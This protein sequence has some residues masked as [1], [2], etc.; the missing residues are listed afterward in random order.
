MT[1]GLPMIER[2]FIT[3]G[4][5]HY[6]EEYKYSAPGG[7]PPRARHRAASHG[8]GR[9]CLPLRRGGCGEISGRIER[10]SLPGCRRRDAQGWVIAER[11]RPDGNPRLRS[12]LG[13]RLPGRGGPVPATDGSTGGEIV[14]RGL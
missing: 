5:T 4:P 10:S 9:Y 7:F 2:T 14:M 12:A 13:F 1:V 3:I 11:K 8:V 6:V